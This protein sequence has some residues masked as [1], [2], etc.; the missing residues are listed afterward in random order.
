MNMKMRRSHVVAVLVVV[1]AFVWG[2]PE[3]YGGTS[4]I[5]YGNPGEYLASGSQTTL[6]SSDRA[7]IRQELGDLGSR[8]NDVKAIFRWKQDHF[9]TEHAKGAFLGTRTVN[10]SMKTRT[11]TGCNDHANLLAAVLRM[12]GI[13]AIIVN[14]AGIQWARDYV[15]R[16]QK[17]IRSPRTKG[18]KEGFKGHAFV[19]AYV[20]GK[21]I[22]I[23]S[24]TGEYVPQGYVPTNPLIPM[25]NR[26]EPIG[27]YAYSKGLDQASTGVH[28][29]RD[30]RRKMV[31]VAPTIAQLTI[32]MPPYSISYL[33]AM[34]K[35]RGRGAF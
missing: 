25:P 4:G 23:N 16:K 1:A 17:G 20:E 28:S 29:M 21:W 26:A 7:M 6:T 3:A 10:E 13:P 31:S 15:S 27:Y 11:L 9:T 33:V 22:L 12:H 32:K 30:S 5:D 24:T 18:K 34:D 2:N 14:A 8:L 19:E 35:R